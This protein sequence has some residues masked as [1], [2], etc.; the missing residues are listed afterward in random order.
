MPGTA[1]EPVHPFWFKQRQGNAEQIGN[2]SMFK[3]SAPNQEEAVILIRQ[4]G[5]KWAAAVRKTEDGEDIDSTPLE[6][7]H[8]GFAWDAAFELY[9][10]HFII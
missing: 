1:T 5:D 2:D 8:P 9:R 7:D 3:L 6:F 4:E 10:Q